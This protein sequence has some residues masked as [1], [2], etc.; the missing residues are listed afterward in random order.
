MT[1]N[2]SKTINTI[3]ILLLGV[4]AILLWL[5]IESDNRIAMGDQYQ[6]HHELIISNIKA[7]LADESF[8]DA[9]VNSWDAGSRPRWWRDEFDA[10]RP[11]FIPT[12]EIVKNHQRFTITLLGSDNQ[13]YQ[14]KIGLLDEGYWQGTREALKRQL[15]NPVRRAHYLN[16]I[17]SAE[18][19]SE[20]ERIA[21]EI[22]QE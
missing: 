14:Y 10:M 19:K 9:Q 6:R 20:L 7:D 5:Q 4:I 15:R 11:D 22:D 18:F 2:Y 1:E 12:L 3:G 17:R 8:V 21:S 16:E 13:Y